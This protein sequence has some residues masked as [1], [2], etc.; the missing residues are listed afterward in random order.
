MNRRS[1]SCLAVVL[2]AIGCSKNDGSS[3]K[4]DL[5]Q[6][7]GEPG[8]VRVKD[9]SLMNRAI[10]K[11]QDTHQEFIKALQ[12]KTPT[13]EGL[14]IKKPFAVGKGAEHIWLNEVSWDGTTFAAVVNNEPVDTKEVK[15]GDHV[16]VKPSEISDW[17]Y[18]DTDG[19]HGGYTVRALYYQ[20]SPEQQKELR[21]QLPFT[22]PPLDF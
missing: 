17:M 7:E 10:K 20:S 3:G 15:L 22:V 14:A 16:R 19:L 6:R 13:M 4:Q 2:F 1:L 21:T 11:A 18:I 9:D 12:N 8:Y 5:I